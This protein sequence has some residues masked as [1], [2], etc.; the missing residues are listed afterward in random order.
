[1]RSGTPPVIHR[2][3]VVPEWIDYNGHFNAGYYVVVFDDALTGWLDHCGLGR[4]RKAALGVTTFTVES[5]TTYLRELSAGDP[6]EITGQLL[7]ST[8]KKIHS[9]LRM[10]HAEDDTLRATNE[11]MTLH[12]DL[13]TRR[14]VAMHRDALDRLSTVSEEQKSL[15]W[16]AQAGRVISVEAK[17]PPLD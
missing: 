3:V 16:P 15:E 10:H 17:R 1:M 13:A 6:L 5:H 8:D 7:R 14:P 4:E 11:V 12:I 9:F 2:A